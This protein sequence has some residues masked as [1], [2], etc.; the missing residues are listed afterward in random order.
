MLE[1][2]TVLHLQSLEATN[3]RLTDFIQASYMEVATDLKRDIRIFTART[4][5]CFSC[6]YWSRF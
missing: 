1:S 5:A 2:G 4:P 3:Q 6:W